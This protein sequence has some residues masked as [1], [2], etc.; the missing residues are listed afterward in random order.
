MDTSPEIY[1]HR[2]GR[3]QILRLVL[4][5]VY[6]LMIAGCVWLCR[7]FS[8][9][10]ILG[11]IVPYGLPPLLTLL[12]AAFLSLF[13][14]GLEQTRTETFL[15]SMICLVF[16][17]LNLDIF[18]LGIIRD[19]D[20]ALA[21][22]RMDHFMLVLVQLGANLHLT[23]LVCGKKDGWWIV[24]GAYGIGAVMSLLT[25]TD[26]YFNGVYTYYWGYFAKKAVLYD[27]MSGLWLVGA[28]YCIFVLIQSWRKSTDPH[29]KDTIR[30]MILGFASS[31][32]LSLTNTPAIYGYEIYPLGTFTFVSLI[33]LAYG[34]FKYNLRIAMQQLRSVLFVGGHLCIVAFASFGVS[35]LVPADSSQRKIAT[36]ILA[37]ILMYQPV[38]RLWDALLNLLI[39]RS[40]VV[41]QQELYLLTAKLSELHRL[42]DI[43]RELCRWLFRIFI[44]SRCAMVVETHSGGVF[45]GW[46]TWNK[47]PFSGF[48]KSPPEIP[49]G[50]MPLRVDPAHPILKQV[51][52]T[53]P[54]L[55]TP[56]TIDRWWAGPKQTFS[57]NDPLFQAGIIIPVFSK[58]QL[59]A[60]VLV[61]NRHNDRS[62]SKTEK[63]AL[64]QIGAFLGPVIENAKLL[65]E[66]EQKVEK[67][68][69]DLHAALGELKGK[70]ADISANNAII[71]NQNRMFLALFE[72][73]TRLHEAETLYDL[74]SF[75]LQQLHFLFPGLGFGI[76]HASARSEA[77]MNGAFVGISDQEQQ[78]ILKHRQNLTEN[79]INRIMNQAA[80]DRDG[81]PDPYV[82]WTLRNLSIRDRQMVEKVI[83]KGPEMDQ[84]TRKV[85]SIFLAQVAIA[86]HNKIL[87]RKLEISAHTDGLTGAA[88][89]VF[90]DATLAETI[91]RSARFPNMHFSVLVIDING[92]KQ[93][94]D[95]FGHD[96][97]D[98]MIQMV[99]KTLSAACR[100]TDTLCRMGGD[101]FVLLLP[102]TTSDQAKTMVERIRRQEAGLRLT[103]RKKNGDP[104]DL[105]VR[106]SIGLAGSDETATDNVIKRADERMYADKKTFYRAVSS[107]ETGDG[108]GA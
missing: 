52:E 21:I 88:N 48:F 27:L 91:A 13:V 83:I 2:L 72:T 3:A 6:L 69:Q 92:L 49:A 36:A 108:A 37:A 53:R 102:A 100:E 80:P 76:V 93:I 56:L 74:F 29:Q 97:G 5:A 81:H 73:S 24:Y 107:P 66:L 25:P 23:Y 26:L 106:F 32:V 78:R 39:K 86:A 42:L 71:Q 70:N 33:L 22:S 10:Y 82:R 9:A 105:P 35:H 47:E 31:A 58:N 8:P 94:N 4:S 65:E 87:M 55:V 64:A 40:S 14:L 28:I 15:F 34:L 41:F 96:K 17:V 104:I 61:G 60:L 19:P 75:T 54:V 7:D 30:F 16:A 46:L 68:T 90:F 85:I 38:A 84:I 63:N 99:A 43:H 62:Y 11:R 103:C 45:S 44:N 57:A 95:Q 50:D 20:I 101:E 89:R 98:E 59:T 12:V 1:Q 18:L 77:A 79:N 67:R 51:R